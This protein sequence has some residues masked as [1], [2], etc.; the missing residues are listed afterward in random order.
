[1]K[2]VYPGAYVFRQEKNIQGNYSNQAHNHY[3]LT[4]EC[5]T[6]EGVGGGASEDTVGGA[7]HLTTTALV[8]RRKV[9]NRNLT[10]IVRRHHQVNHCHFLI[11]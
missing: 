9:F 5:D 8:Q 11:P 1:M 7:G 4:I 3:Q 6:R 2:T 10:K